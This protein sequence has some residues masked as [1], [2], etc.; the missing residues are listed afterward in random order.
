VEVLG[1]QDSATEWELAAWP[2]PDSEIVAGELV[3][4]L[5]MLTLAPVRVPTV[6][7]AYVMVTVAD[8]PGVKIVPSEI[9]LAVSPAPATVTAETVMFEFPLFVTFDVSDLLAPTETVLRFKL[10]GLAPSNAVAVEP[11]PDRLMT[12]GEGWPVI[13]SVR[14]PLMVV[15]EV[16]VKTALNVTLP[17]GAIVVEVDRPVMLN[18]APAAVTCEKIRVVLPVFLSRMGCELVV[19][20]TTLAKLTLAGVAASTPALELVGAALEV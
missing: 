12:S 3:A 13:T 16:G 20:V 10:A 14:D 11:V 19:P 8:C 5:A 4:L 7:G 17:A 18:P 2:E 1:A 9:P 15:V 6:V